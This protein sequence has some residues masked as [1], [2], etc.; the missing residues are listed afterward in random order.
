AVA[1]D[2]SGVVY[3]EIV[4]AVQN[5]GVTS[6]GLYGFSHG[7]GSVYDL[8]ERLYTNKASI[9]DFEIDFTGYIDSIENDSDVDLDA[10]IRRPIDTKYHV[11]YYQ[12]W[13]F[14]PPWG[15][16]VAGAD[17]DVNVTSTSWG[18][19]L[20]HITITNSADVQAGIYEPMVL[21]VQR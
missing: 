3:D 19:F 4:D 21:R 13:G 16:P 11:N 14:I 20:W 18:S 12:H 1:S 8:A 6:L 5:R 7:G 10:E 15:Y 2:G 9:G 17:V